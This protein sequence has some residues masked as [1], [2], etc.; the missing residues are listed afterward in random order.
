MMNNIYKHNNGSADH[1]S[2]N[3]DNSNPGTIVIINGVLGVP[4][5][6]I[7][8]LGNAL[9][10]AAI[11]R[12]PCI[13]STSMI[14]ICS[15]AV[16]DLFVGFVSSSSPSLSNIEH[17]SIIRPVSS[18]LN[19]ELREN[20]SCRCRKGRERETNH[21]RRGGK[22]LPRVLFR[23]PCQFYCREENR[24]KG[25]GF[26]GNWWWPRLA[27][28]FTTR[29]G[30]CA[31]ATEAKTWSASLISASVKHCLLCTKSEILPILLR[32]NAYQF[33][34][35][36]QNRTNRIVWARLGLA[37]ELNRTHRKVPVRLCSINE[38]IEDQSNDYVRLSFVSVSFDWLRRV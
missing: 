22:R 37:I 12:T 5:M 24:R 10:L 14:M 4:L 27:W 28:L 1:H 3:E 9:V 19:K 7:S 8:I 32:L 33:L 13:R 17:K 35:P 21:S 20:N 38:P 23:H 36:K 34:Y 25:C 16:S 6:L 29:T 18:G 11:K 31:L 15:L 26:E 30:T 2:E